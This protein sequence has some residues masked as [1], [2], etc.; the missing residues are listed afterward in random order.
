MMCH[1][2]LFIFARFRHSARA[3]ADLSVPQEMR[4]WEVHN[5]RSPLS[6]TRTRRPPPITRP[7]DLLVRV[8]AASINPIDKYMLRG[9]G[10]S[11]FQLL[12]GIKSPEFSQEF[13]LTPGRDFAGVIVDS[14]PSVSSKFPPGTAVLG[15]TL[16][17][18]SSH[19]SGSLAEYVICDASAV[20]RRPETVEVVKAAALSYAG[21]TA[22]SAIQM[23]GLDPAKHI[24]SSPKRVLVT[25]ASGPVGAIAIQLARLAKASHLTVTCPARFS[26]TDIKSFLGADEVVFAPE[27]PSADTK[28]DAIIDCVRPS[29]YSEPF[30]SNPECRH[31]GFQEYFPLLRNLATSP[32]SRYVTLNPPFLE[33]IDRWG[34]L[35]GTGVSL[36]SLAF[37]NFHTLV[38][39]H[40]SIPLRWAFFKPDGKRLQFLVD[41]LAQG[42][43]RVPI[44]QI[45]PFDQVPEAFKKLENGPTNGK[46]VIKF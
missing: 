11:A 36:A 15:A 17:H 45:F 29:I 28:Y 39:E 42:Q 31:L 16:P 34:V 21:L 44:D 1:S 10:A 2:K 33:F 24:H 13:P 35:Q 32:G 3:F 20:A 19:G 18:T 12:R 25:G 8:E 41:W 7:N 26:K 37:S 6:L 9:Y 38:S 23:A 14:G 46:I 40:G 27:L 30:T 5:F 4:A 22:W 43:I